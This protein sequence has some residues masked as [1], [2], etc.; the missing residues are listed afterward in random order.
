MPGSWII[1]G[2]VTAMAWPMVETTASVDTCTV[3]ESKMSNL[4]ENIIEKNSLKLFFSMPNL[5]EV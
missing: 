3:V 1:V 2:L 5:S 4:A